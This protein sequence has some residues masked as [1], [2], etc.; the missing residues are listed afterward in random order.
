MT[1]CTSVLFLVVTWLARPRDGASS[2]PGNPPVIPAMNY[3]EFDRERSSYKIIQ[4]FLVM[5]SVEPNA[6]MAV[7]T[8]KDGINTNLHKLY[9]QKTVLKAACLPIHYQ[10]N[11]LDSITLKVSTKIGQSLPQ[12]PCQK[13]KRIPYELVT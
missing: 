3:D 12:E 10:V 8:I 11:L 13:P 1:V 7:Y 6:E 2:L 9:S 5:I 4:S